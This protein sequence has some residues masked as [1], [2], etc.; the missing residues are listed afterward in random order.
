MSRCVYNHN[1][2]VIIFI[3]IL[4][5]SRVFSG[6]GEVHVGRVQGTLAL[7]LHLISQK[8]KSHLIF[9][10]R[11]FW[12]FEADNI[13]GPERNAFCF[14]CFRKR[15]HTCINF[16]RCY[17]PDINHCPLVPQWWTL[18]RLTHRQRRGLG[19]TMDQSALCKRTGSP[20]IIK[21]WHFPLNFPSL[22]EFG[23]AGS[24][25]TVV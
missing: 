19:Y 11:F 14:Q 16:C 25:R 9:S 10:S 3:I 24:S 7:N 23:N 17:H 4:S 8:D 5:S 12:D 6:S 1:V 18:D 13:W 21:T 2:I 22:Q 15:N 20:N